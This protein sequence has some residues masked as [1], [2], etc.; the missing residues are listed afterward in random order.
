M[1]YNL[2]SL[3]RLR[4]GSKYETDNA[5]LSMTELSPLNNRCMQD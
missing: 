4:I 3:G 2:E 1:L 5:S